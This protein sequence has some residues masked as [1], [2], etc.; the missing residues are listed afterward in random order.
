MPVDSVFD[1]PVTNLLSTLC[2]LIE[3]LSPAQAKGERIYIFFKLVQIVWHF[4]WSFS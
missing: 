3:I 1:D 4:H 2:I